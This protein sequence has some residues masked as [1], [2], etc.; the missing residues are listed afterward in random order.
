MNRRMA[1]AAGLL[2]LLALGGPAWAFDNEQTFAKGTYV[3][4]FEGGYGVQFNL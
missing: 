4:S 2:A 3:F 1:L